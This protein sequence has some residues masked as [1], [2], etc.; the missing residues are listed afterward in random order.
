MLNVPKQIPNT[1]SV[2][3]TLLFS[4]DS[5]RVLRYHVINSVKKENAFQ[6]QVSYWQKQNLKNITAERYCFA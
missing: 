1:W 2:K 3:S 4:V 5:F 6:Y